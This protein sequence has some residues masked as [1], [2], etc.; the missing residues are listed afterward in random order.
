MGISSVA[1]GIGCGEDGVDEDE[2]AQD[3]GAEAFTLGVAVADK[4]GSSPQ[5]LILR[6]LERLYHGGSSN[7][8]EALHQDVE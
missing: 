5:H 1:L 6:L 8:S 7:R 3:L 4:V 2:G